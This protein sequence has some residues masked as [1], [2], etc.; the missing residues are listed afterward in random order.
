[1]GYLPKFSNKSVMISIRKPLAF[2]KKDLQNES[3]Y[4]F[5]F[6]TQI[7]GIFLTVV[8]IFFLSILLRDHAS[9]YLEKYGGSY[10]SFVLVG[11]AVSSYLQVSLNSFAKTVR[12]AQLLGT[13]EALLVTPTGVT[14]IITSSSLYSFL[15]TS[16]RVVA[17]LLCGML[18]FGF[19][20]HGAN[21][22]GGFFVLFLTVICF[23]SLGIMS[24]A[25]VMVL[26][27]GDPITWV[28]TSL[29]WLLSGV[30]Y[31]VSVLPEWL[32]GLAKALP[33][34]HSLEAMRLTLLQGFSTTQV[35]DS[36]ISLALLTLIFLP[37][38]IFMFKYAVTRT[39]ITGS[40]VQY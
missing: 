24:A 35:M 32:Q 16:L 28:F 26:K 40:L 33:M 29:S 8:S 14:T 9:P 11:I 39:K 22:I 30:Y 10:F 4:K 2:L 12:N 38:S 13:L 23:S 20:L 1:M 31:P 37:T 7:S 34:T 21:I 6:I 17:Y 3:S 19:D 5:S 36:I 15:F 18:G 27:K 25:F